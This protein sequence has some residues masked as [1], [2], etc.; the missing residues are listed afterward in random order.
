MIGMAMD[1]WSRRTV[2]AATA[3]APISWGTTAITITEFLP[4]GRP[5][6]VAAMRVLP[7]GLVLVAL[8]SR[9]TGWRPVGREWLRYAVLA[10]CNFALFFPLLAAG[11]YRLPGGVAASGGGLQPM[12]VAGLTWL[13]LRRRPRPIDLAVGVVAAV[14][15]A[16]VVIR[17]GAGF[18]H[19]GLLA[20]VSANTAFAVGV[21]LTKR[22]PVPVNRTATTGWQLLLGAAL[23]VPLALVVEGLPSTLTVRNVGGFAYLSLFGTGLAYIVWFNG[24]RRLPSVAPPLLGLA[25]PVTGAALGWIVLGQSLSAVQL[26]GFAL[27]LGAIS[28]GALQGARANR[29]AAS[30]DAVL[31]T[32]PVGVAQHPL[33]ELPGGQAR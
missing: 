6:L 13:L 33:V 16:M 24:I 10:T 8:G 22:M 27:A 23:L 1:G 3:L 5:L 25:A 9:Q 30:D 11:I 31:V 20:M 7:A 21:V 26:L 14:G 17:P 28:Y 2:V 19:V 29:T 32:R 12:L 4:A 18:N 15:V